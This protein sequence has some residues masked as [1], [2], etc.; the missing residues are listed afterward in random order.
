MGRQLATDAFQR[1]AGKGAGCTRRD[2][3]HSGHRIEGQIR[4]IAQI[5]DLALAR[6]EP[7]DLCPDR[8]A[9]VTIS[10]LGPAGPVDTV[11]LQPLAKPGQPPP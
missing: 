4:P 7:V 8:Q 5:Q 10:G 3:Q 9:V 6:R 11:A 2:P 1:S